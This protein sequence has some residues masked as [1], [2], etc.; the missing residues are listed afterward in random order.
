MRLIFENRGKLQGKLRTKY[1]SIILSILS[2]IIFVLRC[3][4]NSNRSW[5]IYKLCAFRKKNNK[6]FP[7]YLIACKI[8]FVRR[9]STLQHRTS[10]RFVLKIQPIFD[11][12]S[13]VANQEISTWMVEISRIRHVNATMLR[14]NHIPS[15]RL[16][17]STAAN[18]VL[19][20]LPRCRFRSA[21]LEWRG[22][23]HRSNEQVGTTCIE[24]DSLAIDAF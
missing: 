20:I 23:I 5:I 24:D 3:A 12:Q 15:V 13:F 6:N 14:L 9:Q 7:R 19:L 16:K 10:I 4:V 17:H 11:K 8:F 18:C 22:S 21:R 1:S 2:I